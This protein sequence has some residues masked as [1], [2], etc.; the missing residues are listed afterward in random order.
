MNAITPSQS[1]D[2]S[3][4]QLIKGSIDLC[5]SSLDE[6][7]SVAEDCIE[8]IVKIS[9]SWQEAGCSAKKTGGSAVG[10]AEELLTGPIASLR[11]LRLI[12]KTLQDLRSDGRPK[13]PGVPKVVAGQLRVPVFPTPMMFDPI[14]FR[15]LKG[16]TWLE[17]GVSQNQIFGDAPE[18]LLREKSVEPKIELVL[19][20]GNVSSIPVTDAMTKIFQDDCVVLL[21]MNPVNQY[22]GPLFE[23]ALKP[24]IQVGWLR[25]VYGAASEG[26]YAI[27]HPQVNSVH[28]TGSCD[29]HEAI[30][31]GGDPEE[32]QR[33]KQ[34]GRPLLDKPI[35][36][37]L[38]NV[39]PWI[40]IPGNYSDR[41]LKSQAESIAASITNNASFNCVATKMLITWKRWSQREKFLGLL[42]SILDRSEQRFAYY[43]GAEQRFEQFAGYRP[44]DVGNGCLPW[45]LKTGVTVEE[46]PML[47]ERES[48]VCVSGETALDADS[49]VSFLKKAVEFVNTRMTGTLAAEMT[50]PD[51]FRKQESSVFDQA[52]RE[53]RYGTI[54]IN[55]W[56]GL[57][58]AWMSPPWG[59]FPGASLE[60][61]QSGIGSVHNTYLL[62]RPQKSIIDAPLCISPK[63]VWFSNHRCPDKVAERLLALYSNPSLL[64]LPGLFAAALSG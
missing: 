43:P 55:Q 39:T 63:P 36:S 17:P 31:W 1:I 10:R 35:S 64:K 45:T 24:L 9:K 21:K 47:F 34:D 14:A 41:Q 37:E 52:L 3:I 58:F 44:K 11:Y 25:I 6:R 2:H 29:T 42:Q 16:E 13:L 19:G 57:G 46:Q 12:I 23:Q 8:G 18:R 33:R 62:N 15:G 26:A 54:G 40:I 38:G 60:D 30:V 32:R 53:L 50:V 20:A 27:N 48:F 7:V 22:L 28:I 61:V 56:S 5:S 51:S 49:P 59:G 4:E